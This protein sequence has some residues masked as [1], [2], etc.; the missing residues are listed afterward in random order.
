M[1]TADKRAILKKLGRH[2]T[3]IRKCQKLT[4]QQVGQN[5]N[6]NY[7]NISKIEKGRLNLTLC[8]LME[9]S[10]GLGVEPRSLVDINL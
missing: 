3:V 6:V 10:K 5:C 9:L 7:S 2:I 4:Y 1:I 8:T